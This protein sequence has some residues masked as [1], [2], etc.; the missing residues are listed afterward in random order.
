[1]GQKQLIRQRFNAI[2]QKRDHY[3]CRVCRTQI[4]LPVVHHI[5]D[6]SLMPFGG[7]VK[8]NG[9]TL[10]DVCHWKAEEYHR[11]GASFDG[12]HPDDLYK[13]I[14]SNYDAAYAASLLT[15]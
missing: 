9:I 2:C 11:T 14:N 5:T 6:R 12:F 7:Y 3:R 15:P 4:G 8:E 10:C 1:M 13:I